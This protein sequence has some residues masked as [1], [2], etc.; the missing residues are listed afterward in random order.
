MGFLR[1][2]DFVCS[3]RTWGGFGKEPGSGF[4][5]PEP[6]LENRVPDLWHYSGFRGL[7]ARGF[8]DFGVRWISRG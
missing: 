2:L 3:G 7:Q 6:V 8:E 4:Q 5:F 1:N